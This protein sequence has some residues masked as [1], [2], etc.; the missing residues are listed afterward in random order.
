MR[1][2]LET[3]LISPEQEQKIKRKLPNQMPTNPTAQGW[4]GKQIQKFL[5]R[6][7]FDLDGSL[8]SELKSK[9]IATKDAFAAV[10]TEIDAIRT[11]VSNISEL[12]DEEQIAEIL[13]KIAVLEEEIENIGGF[14]EG[15]LD[16]NNKIRASLLPS[17][18]FGGMRFVTTWGDTENNT[19]EH[20]HTNVIDPYITSNGGSSRGCYVIVART[21]QVSVSNG[22]SLYMDEIETEYAQLPISVGL[23]PIERGDWLIC[24]SDDGKTWAVINNAYRDATIVN[25]GIVQLAKEHEGVDGTSTALAMTPAATAAAIN[26][27]INETLG[28]IEDGILSNYYDKTEID[29]MIG[30]IETLLEGI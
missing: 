16:E 22:Y 5:T 6:A 29:D 17:F 15:L 26:A 14:V 19:L 20:L 13:T 25:K 30:D 28:D 23:I 21:M 8:Y 27:A 4:S 12:L 11:Q 1:P 10:F 18:V 2:D 9:M 24:I 7:I 3:L